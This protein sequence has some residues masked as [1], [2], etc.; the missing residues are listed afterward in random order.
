MNALTILPL[1]GKQL[2]LIRR[3]VAADCNAAEFDQFI[4][5]CKA[6]RLD[7]LRRQIYAFVFSKDD[8]SKRKMT[9]ITGIDGYRAIAERTQNYRPDTQ[10]P[11]ITYDAAAKDKKN[12][13]GIIR[14]EVTVFKF[15]HGHW[16]PVTGEA[17]WD[18]YAPIT[19]AGDGGTDWEETGQF[20]PPGHA[21]AGKPKYRKV[22]LGEVSET[23]D[24]TKPNWRKMARVM[25]SKCAEAQAIRRAWPDDF[26]GLEVEEEVDRRASLDLTATE[27]ADQVA[28]ERRFNAIGGSNAVTVDWLDG[29]ALAREPVG[30]FGDKVLAF[31]KDYIDSPSTI[32]AFQ[33]R[34]ETALRE[35]WA[36]D[37][38]GALALKKAF[39]AAFDGE[40]AE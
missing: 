36:H 11:R 20:Y 4:H 9:V 32:K 19:S 37:K 31:I 28:T 2:E 16:F 15:V 17:Y 38:S 13:L 29:N 34:N 23:L 5:I 22:Q 35:Y 7:P 24:P 30:T 10:A 25:I 12:P 39:E 1:E 6:V 14:A 3:T 33:T 26:S 18:E 21:K 27:E 40:A 8:P